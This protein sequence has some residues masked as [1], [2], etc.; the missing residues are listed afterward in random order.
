TEGQKNFL[1]SRNRPDVFTKRSPR[2]SSADCWIRC[3]RNALTIAELF[4]DV[5]FASAIRATRLSIIQAADHTKT[6]LGGSPNPP[7]RR[8]AVA[9][10]KLVKSWDTISGCSSWA[11]WPPC[12]LWTPLNLVRPCPIV[13]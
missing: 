5:E 1:N 11:Q 6:I 8:Q 10:R 13:S 12:T 3:Y 9:A 7:P 2:S 4:D